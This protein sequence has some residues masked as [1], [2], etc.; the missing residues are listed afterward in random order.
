MV[1][2]IPDPFLGQIQISSLSGKTR[3]CQDTFIQRVKENKNMAVMDPRGSSVR[4]QPRY[5]FIQLL[6][7]IK[8]CSQMDTNRAI[9]GNT[10]FRI[11]IIHL[12]YKNFN[13][14]ACNLF[15]LSRAVGSW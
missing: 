13:M 10:I 12:A 14:S 1:L 15:N 8:I 4:P 9:S 5:T 2:T 6:K 7:R 11:Y 3:P